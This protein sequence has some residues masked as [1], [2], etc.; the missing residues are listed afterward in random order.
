MFIPE[1][2]KLN[3]FKDVS[4]P[5]ARDYFKL[6]GFQATPQSAYT[7]DELAPRQMNKVESIEDF[8]RYCEMKAEEDRARESHGNNN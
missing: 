6:T 3:R 8:E 5:S 7:G 4:L 2:M 1:K